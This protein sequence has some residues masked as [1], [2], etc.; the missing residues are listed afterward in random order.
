VRFGEIWSRR[1]RMGVDVEIEGDVGIYGGWR[2][3]CGVGDVGWSVGS[4]R[5]GGSGQ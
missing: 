2:R 1:K 4:S 5:R 3:D